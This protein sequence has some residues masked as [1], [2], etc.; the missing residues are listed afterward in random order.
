MR[1]H[2]YDRVA[3]REEL[4]VVDSRHQWIVHDRSGAFPLE[5]IDE[6]RREI[7]PRIVRVGL[8]RESE[9]R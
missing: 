1:R 8:K 3:P 7:V 2:Q 5:Q 4:G 9:Y 6:R